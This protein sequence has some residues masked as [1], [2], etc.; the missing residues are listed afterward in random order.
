V[1]L[2]SEDFLASRTHLN[3]RFCRKGIISLAWEEPA[4]S[5]FPNSF[6]GGVAVTFVIHLVAMWLYH[7]VPN[8]VLAPITTA[9]RARSALERSKWD[10]DVK[11][12]RQDKNALYLASLNRLLYTVRFFGLAGVGSLCLFIAGLID[13]LQI[14]FPS[15]MAGFSSHSAAERVAVVIVGLCLWFLAYF[16][17]LRSSSLSTL[18][19][20]ASKPE[21]ADAPS[22]R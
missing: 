16:E 20:A 21:V 10:L 15:D 8:L 19:G 17:M 12:L 7:R 1:D 11:A 3:P 22:V 4:M 18:I 13:F 14:H 2:R 9:W 6:W 5:E